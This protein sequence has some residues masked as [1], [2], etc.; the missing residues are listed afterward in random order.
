MRMPRGLLKLPTAVSVLVSTL[1]AALVLAVLPP[2]LGLMLFAAAV[3]LLWALASGALEGPTVRLLV[4]ARE[5]TE[6]ERAVLVPVLGGLGLPSSTVYVRRSPRADSPPAQMVGRSSLVVAPW[7]IESAV[8]G[9][10]TCAETAALVVHAV[11]RQRAE[12]SRF[13][14]AILALT[15]PWRAVSTAC[16]RIGRVFAWFPLMRLAWMLRGVVAVVGVVQS[17]TSGRLWAGLL[18]GGFVTLTYLIPAAA[19]ARAARVE[20]AADQ[21]VVEAGLG[22]VLAALLRRSQQPVTADRL[23]RLESVSRAQPVPQPA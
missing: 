11:G 1:L 7:L 5:A 14:V 9:W 23:Q 20:T 16:R 3:A 2:A 19:R 22:E 10:T 12:R 8:R 17:A 18:A 21:F 13:E 6:V 4:G 15:T